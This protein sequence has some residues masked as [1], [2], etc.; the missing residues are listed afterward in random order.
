MLGTEHRAGFPTWSQMHMENRRQCWLW[1]S[2]WMV[3]PHSTWC[4][5]LDSVGM[6]YRLSWWLR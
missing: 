6:K 2:L 5:D 4:K 1:G 3:G